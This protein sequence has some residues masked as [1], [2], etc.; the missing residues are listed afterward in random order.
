[1]HAERISKRKTKMQHMPDA[2]DSQLLQEADRTL[3]A[4]T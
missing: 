3:F 4:L 1:M 2:K